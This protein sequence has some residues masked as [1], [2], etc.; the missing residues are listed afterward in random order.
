MSALSSPLVDVAMAIYNDDAGHESAHPTRNR[1]VG[2]AREKSVLHRVVNK[3]SPLAFGEA[4]HT[5]VCSLHY[6]L[7][8]YGA[9]G[10]SMDKL[11][12]RLNSEERARL[13]ELGARL[14]CERVTPPAKRARSE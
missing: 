10:E 11:L 12:M 7:N 1:L 3:G 14:P 4:S 6:L 9:A 2:P 13:R 8:A 5:S